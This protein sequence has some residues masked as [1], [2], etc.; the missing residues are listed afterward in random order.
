MLNSSIVPHLNM[1]Q[2]ELY[3][4]FCNLTEMS[5]RCIVMLILHSKYD[6]YHVYYTNTYA[7]IGVFFISVTPSL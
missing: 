3:N 1:D 2:I 5:I 7:F 6:G 4:Q